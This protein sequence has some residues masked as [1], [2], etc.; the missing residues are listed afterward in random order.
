MMPTRAKSERGFI[1][2]A[3]SEESVRTPE[4]EIARKGY[5]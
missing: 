2:I 3:A 4:S 5:S 1:F